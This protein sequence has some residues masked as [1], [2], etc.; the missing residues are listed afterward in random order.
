ME[1]RNKGLGGRR[2]RIPSTESNTILANS[3]N[4]MDNATCSKMKGS[5]EQHLV[6][7]G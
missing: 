4:V 7:E 1:N 3:F 2:I 5:V 6:K